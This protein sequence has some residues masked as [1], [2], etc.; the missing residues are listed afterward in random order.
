VLSHG[1]TSQDAGRFL[2]WLFIC[3]E[4]GLLGG[5]ID[6]DWGMTGMSFTTNNEAI[7]EETQDH[8]HDN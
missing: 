7:N 4:L 3:V 6:I 5:R 8:D 1:R 2:F